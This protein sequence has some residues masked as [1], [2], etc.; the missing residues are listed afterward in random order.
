MY[1]EVL[2]RMRQCA[3]QG[4]IIVTNHADDAMIDDGINRYDI[5]Y[6]IMTGKII[7]RQ[8][9]WARAEYKYRVLGS[10]YSGLRMEVV[11]RLDPKDCTVIITVYLL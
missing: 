10:T 3:R 9:D 8:R 2:L 4:R 6:T 11:A 5:E 1:E 7:A